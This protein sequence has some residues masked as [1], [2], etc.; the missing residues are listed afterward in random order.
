MRAQL[1]ALDEA[2]DDLYVGP[3]AVIHPDHH[4]PV[5]LLRG[6][7]DAGGARGGHRQRLLHQHVEVGGERREDVRLVQVIG[8]ADHDGVERLEAQQVLDVVER[9]L[10][11]E[12]VGQR[13]G[14][15]Q[16]GV[17]DGLHLDGLELLEH[18]QVG[19]LGDR[20]R[21]R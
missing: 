16:I 5:A 2:A 15:R 1:A 17:A 13:A 20:A 21:R 9:V 18:R 8:R 10:D 4:D 7:D 11:R 6:P 3:V 19:D 12:P 14:L